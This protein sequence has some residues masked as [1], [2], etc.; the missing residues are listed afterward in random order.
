VKA[1]EFPSIQ[2]KEDTFGKF[3]AVASAWLGSKWSFAGAISVVILWAIMGPE[4]K[5]TQ[6]RDARAIN[7]KL[8]ELTHS[9]DSASN[10]MMDIEKLSD[11]ELDELQARF[12]EIRAECLRREKMAEASPNTA[13]PPLNLG[14]IR[15]QLAKGQYR[16]LKG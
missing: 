13:S 5:N 14:S 12:E 16:K 15:L 6:N 1:E 10:R 4:F 11:V 2:H 3:A 8:D 9:I 7:L